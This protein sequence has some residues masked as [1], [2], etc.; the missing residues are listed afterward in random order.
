MGGPKNNKTYFCS[1]QSR[2]PSRHSWISPT[3]KII[4]KNKTPKRATYLYPSTATKGNGNSSAIST[5]K[6]K[7]ITA[8]KK[9]RTEKGTREE[10]LGS[11]PHSK[12]DPFSRS[13]KV[14]FANNHAVKQT[15]RDK[16]KQKKT[17]VITKNIVTSRINILYFITSI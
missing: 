1:T 17:L 11:N 6:I 7:K 4:T 13:K 12:G 14:R 10:D 3:T 15:A 9:N 16:K 2:D 5:S 8:N